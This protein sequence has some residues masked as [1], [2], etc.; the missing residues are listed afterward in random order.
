MKIETK[1]VEEVV[2]I[3]EV[4]TISRVILFNDNYH[5]F[6]QVVDQLQKAIGCSEE[7]AFSLAYTIHT[8]GK[9]EV[10]RGKILD[11][12]RVSSILR[13]INLKTQIIT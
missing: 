1:E 10:F 12:V 4:T 11:C 3:S 13:E 2:S 9:C 8:A 7:I 6:N 5:T